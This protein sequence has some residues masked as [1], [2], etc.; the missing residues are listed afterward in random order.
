MSIACGICGDAE[1]CHA[2]DGDNRIEDYL[3]VGRGETPA[4]AA[5]RWQA[6]AFRAEEALEAL[7]HYLALPHK[8]IGAPCGV[9]ACVVCLAQATVSEALE[10]RR[11]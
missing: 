7:T 1:P 3:T 10:A 6:R 2:H 4:A 5:M 11:I 9:D 8:D